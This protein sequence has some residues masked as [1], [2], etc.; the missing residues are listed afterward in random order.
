MNSP[1]HPSD[2]E[3]L[4]APARSED[5]Q[6]DIRVH[7]VQE[8]TYLMCLLQYWYNAGSVNTYGGLVRQESKLMLFIFYRI[9]AM[10]NPYG[11]YIW[12]HEVMDNTLWL[13]YYQVHTRLEQHI[14][15]YESHLHMIKG[16][17]ILWNWLR[18]CYLVEATVEWRHLQLYGGSLDRLPFPCSYEDQ[19]PSNKGPFYHSR[20]I[21]PNEV[22]PTMENAPQVANTMLEALARHNHRQSEARN[23]QEYQQQQDNTEYPMADIPSPMPVDQDEPMDLEGLESATAAP[24]PSSSATMV[25][26]LSSSTTSALAKKKTSIEEYNHHKPTEWDL[27]SAYL[28]RDK[29][30]EDLDYEDFEPQDDP[31]NIQISYWTPMPVPQIVDLPPLQDAASLAS[32]LATTLVASDVTIPMPQGNTSPGTIPGTTAHNVATAANQA[33]SFSRGFPVARAS[34]MQ[35]GTPPASAS[36]IQVTTPAALPHRTPRHAFAAEEALL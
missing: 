28:N 10:L 8:W 18:N 19:Q 7:C 23:C 20:G 29:N 13:S 1:P 35:V 25:P 21:H 3:P 17:D 12:L 31:A 32:Q 16:L 15:D 9:N 26:P 27:A 5:Y 33:P 14:A 22:K 11:I 2:A 6:T 30:R 24:Q 34:P 36:L 4:E